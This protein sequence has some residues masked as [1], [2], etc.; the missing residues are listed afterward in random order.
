MHLSG[1][2]ME[3]HL[4]KTWRILAGEEL[5]FSQQ[6]LSDAELLAQ[7]YF[8]VT[9]TPTP[10][11]HL[12]AVGLVLDES[13]ANWLTS[14]MFEMPEDQLSPADVVDACTELCNVFAG[15]VPSH[16]SDN[17]TLDLGI[18]SRLSAT[19]FSS[20]LHA[21]TLNG[22]YLAQN[23]NRHIQVMIFEN[24]EIPADSQWNPVA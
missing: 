18:P 11:G 24:L 4:A 8:M 15:G 22:C 17:V 12:A 9:L 16:I 23:N 2:G 13:D 1:M 20:I 21:S 7:H 14:H 19:Q 5:C 10:A 3:E 6:T